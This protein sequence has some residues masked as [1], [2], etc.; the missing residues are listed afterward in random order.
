MGIYQNKGEAAEEHFGDLSVSESYSGHD[1][2]QF[3]I[4]GENLQNE[5]LDMKIETMMYRIDGSWTC[6][7][8]G[9]L[10]K[11]RK[12]MVRH[13]EG[14]HIDG[15]THLCNLC[16]AELRSRHSLAIHKSKHNKV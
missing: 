5:E 13:I 14:K 10:E 11:G 3:A 12:N 6:K 7:P 16:G 9:K 8:C 4:V 2:D 15:V 1:K